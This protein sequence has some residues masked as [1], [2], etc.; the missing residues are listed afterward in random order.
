MKATSARLALLA[1]AALLAAVAGCREVEK[2]TAENLLER[3]SRGDPSAM[4]TIE[5]KGEEAIPILKWGLRHKKDKIRETAF[6]IL[7]GLAE[8]GSKEAK[9]IIDDVNK[10]FEGEKA[11]AYALHMNLLD[12]FGVAPETPVKMAGKKVGFVK[13]IEKE[14]RFYKTELAIFGSTKI[15]KDSM[16]KRAETDLGDAY[17]EI[18]PG[19][20]P[21]TMAAGATILEDNPVLKD[22]ADGGV[23][24][25]DKKGKKGKKGK[26]GR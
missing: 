13:E 23:P 10:E 18:V 8:K 7:Q 20:A 11:D 22:I 25:K 19:K 9:S 5:A 26:R 2:E 24:D 12:A 1:A 4:G 6:R 3:A 21:E 17:I 15:P 16:A 14:D